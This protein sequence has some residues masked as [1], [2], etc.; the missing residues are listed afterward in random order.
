MTFSVTMSREA[1]TVTVNGISGTTNNQNAGNWLE[2]NAGKGHPGVMVKTANQS[3]KF[4]DAKVMRLHVWKIHGNLQKTET[5][6]HS[7]PEYINLA[8]VSGT[9]TA[10]DG[11]AALKGATVRFGSK[12]AKTDDNGAYQIEDVEVGTY[13]AA[14][15]CPGYEAITQE[16]EVQDAAEGE[17]VFN[18]TLSEK[19]A[20]RP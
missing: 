13:T 7:L 15:S 9:V 12:S 6:S 2:T 11:G 8:T 17:N 4:A 20:D 18:F 5:D 1:L 19:N 14:A 3:L 16:V 10:K